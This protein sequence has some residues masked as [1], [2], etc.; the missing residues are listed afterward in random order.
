MLTQRIMIREFDPTQ[1]KSTEL[2]VSLANLAVGE[3]GLKVL[4]ILIIQTLDK[5]Q[6]FHPV[7]MGIRIIRGN[8]DQRLDIFD[9]C[10]FS[11]NN[12]K[13]MSEIGGSWDQLISKI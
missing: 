13:I 4:I 1:I 10:Y 7:I 9:P 6:M 8:F 2:L 3:I 12:P 11:E 5:I